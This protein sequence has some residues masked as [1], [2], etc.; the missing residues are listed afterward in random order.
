MK[1]ILN[2]NHPHHINQRD[3]SSDSCIRLLV[4]FHQPFLV[5]PF[6]KIA[7]VTCLNCDLCDF[8]DE[9]DFKCQSSPSY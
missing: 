7:P 8:F 1:M 3:H 6:I 4:D 9:D 5:A 2:A